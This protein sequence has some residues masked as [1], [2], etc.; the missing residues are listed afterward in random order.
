M[1]S[2]SKLN[3]WA[4]LEGDEKT[5]GITAANHWAPYHNSRFTGVLSVNERLAIKS[6]TI[7]LYDVKSA[8]ILQACM[9]SATIRHILCDVCAGEVCVGG[10]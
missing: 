6:A 1:K 3:H 4:P 7:I 2:S 9:R 10:V 8:T 5:T